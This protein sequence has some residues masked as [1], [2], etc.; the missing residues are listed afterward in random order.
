MAGR[1]IG[2]TKWKP[3]PACP[4]AAEMLKKLYE[5]VSIIYL[6]FKSTRSRDNG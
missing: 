3:G 4:E 1:R 6:A 5:R 2:S